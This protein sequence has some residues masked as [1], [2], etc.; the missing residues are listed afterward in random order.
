MEQKWPIVNSGRCFYIRC[1][2]AI[3]ATRDATVV[4]SVIV[5]ATAVPCAVVAFHELANRMKSV[6]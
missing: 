3:N 6:R 1:F 5:A 2:T 4:A